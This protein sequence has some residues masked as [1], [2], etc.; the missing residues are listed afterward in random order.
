MS[1]LI[2]AVLL[3]ASQL[4]AE[5]GTTAAQA[6]DGLL[7]P[8]CWHESLTVHRSET[9]SQLRTEIQ[10]MAAAGKSAAQIHEAMVAR[11]GVRILREP[12]GARAAW[13]Y[14]LPAIASLL[15]AFAA[16]LF[17]KR[18]LQSRQHAVAIPEGFSLPD[19]GDDV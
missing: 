9:A 1:T 10:Q 6:I 5:P 18:H 8:C 13:L 17:L 14:T 3:A 7:A 12:P 16:A 4:L 2:F 15:G 11:Y 19:I